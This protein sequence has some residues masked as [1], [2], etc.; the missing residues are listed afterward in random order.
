M[1]DFPFTTPAFTVAP[2]TTV[3]SPTQM[4]VFYRGLPNPVEVSVP[5]VSMNDLVVNISSGHKITGSGGN[6]TVTPGKNARIKEAEISVSAK[7]PTGQ[8]A[9]WDRRSSV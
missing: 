4:N 8:R 5:G 9:P 2:P 3:V 6:H 1:T 7:L